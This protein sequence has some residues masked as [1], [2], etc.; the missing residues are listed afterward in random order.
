MKKK[1]SAKPFSILGYKGG[2]I[3]KKKTKCQAPLT[4]GKKK[5]LQ[6]KLSP[7]MIC[8]APLTHGQKKWKKNEEKLSAKPLWHMG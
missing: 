1:L 5:M 3:L 8:Q 4:I 6:K 7:G 2:K